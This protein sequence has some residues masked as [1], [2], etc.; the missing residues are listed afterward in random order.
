MAVTLPPKPI[1]N[2]GASGATG[3]RFAPSIS[4]VR[5]GAVQSGNA[6]VKSAPNATAAT[7][8]TSAGATAPVSALETFE[9][10]ATAVVG[11]AADTTEAVVGYAGAI[12]FLAGLAGGVG[13]TGPAQ[14]FDKNLHEAL[15]AGKLKGLAKLVP[16]SMRANT[17]GSAMMNGSFAAASAFGM[18]HTA[19]GFGAACRL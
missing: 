2:V 1:T 3:G 13:V 17:V 14:W 5:R 8:N 11:A 19:Q 15:G 6:T 7:S 4:S 9:A 18:A 12:P 10:K 16:K